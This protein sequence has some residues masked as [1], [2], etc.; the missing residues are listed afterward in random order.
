M[1]S[2]E[3]EG[4]PESCSEVQASL[5]LYVGADL[6][7]P[8]MDAVDAH[9]A[10]CPACAALHVRARA[11]RSVLRELRRNQ[12]RTA[13]SDLPSLW[14][15][16]RASLVEENLFAQPAAEP[17]LVQPAFARASRP[18]SWVR[19]WY[20]WSGVAA[21]A[22][23]LALWPMLTRAPST[24]PSAGEELAPG[25]A[26]VTEKE[27]SPVSPELIV[28]VDDWSNGIRPLQL[29]DQN[30]PSLYDRAISGQ[31]PNRD[32]GALLRSAPTDTSFA[33]LNRLRLR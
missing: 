13:S 22:A 30:E 4:L 17:E 7:A 31:G 20:A 25:V 5:S 21:A 12:V 3:M 26:N 11:A 33:G 10:G 15:G 14:A 24:V 27:E 1:V 19:Q 29:A 2:R 18:R 23:A 32:G 28:P 16:I 9:L 8:A 6:E